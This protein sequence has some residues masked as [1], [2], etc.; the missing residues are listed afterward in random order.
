[1]IGFY[2]FEE[3]GYPILKN[4][5]EFIEFIYNKSDMFSLNNSFG[6]RE[7]TEELKKNILTLLLIAMMRI[8]KVHF[9]CL[10]IP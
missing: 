7:M 2:C 1:M 5:R 9:L 8:K 4:Y 3:E 10:I 6:S